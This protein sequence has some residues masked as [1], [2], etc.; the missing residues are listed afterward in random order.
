M[1]VYSFKCP[2]CG[3]EFDELVRRVGQKAPCPNC[4]CADVA[5][6]I[7]APAPHHG[8]GNQAEHGCSAPP[9]SPFS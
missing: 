7:T 2:E 9:R 8:G 6:Q 1:P 4:G 5:V 3:H